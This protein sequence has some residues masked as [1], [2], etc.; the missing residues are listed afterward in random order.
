MTGNAKEFLLLPQS[1]LAFRQS[2]GV[3]F[4][5]ATKTA[6]GFGPKSCGTDGKPTPDPEPPQGSEENQSKTLSRRW[7][8]EQLSPLIGLLT[9]LQIVSPT[10]GQRT[11]AW[12]ADALG[13]TQSNA[14]VNSLE[15][16]LT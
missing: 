10:L 1:S 16:K 3:L 7:I 5:R 14:S 8:G 15:T 4:H 12:Q 13:E 2:C 9:G 6:F 11:S